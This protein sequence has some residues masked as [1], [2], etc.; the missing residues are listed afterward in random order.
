MSQNPFAGG[1]STPLGAR[2]I[3]PVTPDTPLQFVAVGLYVETGGALEFVT[4]AGQTRTIT[5]PSFA[6]V[7]VGCTRV[8]SAGTTATGIHAYL[9]S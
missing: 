4:E 2:D 7:P 9:V 8:N 3:V 6:V 1:N 5:V